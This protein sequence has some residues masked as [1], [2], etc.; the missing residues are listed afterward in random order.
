VLEFAATAL[1]PDEIS[2]QLVV[3]SGSCDVNGS[4]RP[5]VEAHRP[6]RYV[7]TDIREG[8]GVDAVCPAGDLPLLFGCNTAGVVIATEMLEHAENWQVALTGL[9]H[10]LMP[11]GPLLLTTRSEGFSYH[12]HPDFWRFSLAAISTILKTAG[13]SV[14]RCEPDPECPGVFAKARKP[15]FWQWHGIQPEWDNLAGVTRVNG[16]VIPSQYG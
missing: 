13:F 14:E 10:V 15:P 16:G 12:C 9:I 3:E 4:V 6:A 5:I 2:G 8:P 7:G 11:G 1:D